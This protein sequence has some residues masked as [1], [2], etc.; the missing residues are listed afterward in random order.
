MI[1]YE[2]PGIKIIQG[3][4]LEMLKELPD[5]SI[6]TV[7]TSPPYWGLRDYQTVPQIWDG[8]KDCQHSW[9][10]Y[11][12]PAN[13]WGKPNANVPGIFK[14]P[15]SNKPVVK[16]Q[17]LHFCS[18]CGA[19]KGS[20]GLEPSPELFVKH[21]TDIFREIKRILKKEGTVWLNLG[22]SYVSGKSRYSSSPQ[23]IS[24]KDRGE[25]TEQNKP[26]LYYHPYLKDKDLCGIPWRVAFALQQPYKVPV[27]VK[28]ETDR[29][30]LAAMFDGE[31][32]IG[33]RR[34]SSYRKEVE[35]VYQDGFVAYTVVT[36]NDIELLEKC[37]AI[38]GKGKVA[39]KQ[40]ANTTDNRGIV[41]R[42]DSYGW[43]LDG[44]DAVD[45]VR[46]IYPYLIAKR[47]Q[48][49]LVYTL[50][51]IHKNKQRVDGKVPKD[52][53]DKK[54][55]LYETI[56]KCNQRESVNIPNWIEEPKQKIEDGWY[57]RQDIIWQ[58]PN[59]MP[60]S[61]TDRCT[62][63]HEYI[64]LLTKSPKYYFDNEAIKE[65]Q[66]A[67]SLVRAFATDHLDKRK[68]GGDE[69]YALSG[70]RQQEAHSKLRMVINSGE[71]P[72][73]NKRSVWTVTTKSFK[74]AHFATFNEEL[75]LPCVLAG[76]PKEGIILDPFCGSGTTGAVAKN[77]MR[78]FIGIELNA[79]Y[80]EI[81]KQRIKGI[82]RPML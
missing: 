4:C 32:C 66:A 61:V 49:C 60:E 7:I 43:R 33:I 82:T 36:N 72:M 69:P 10:G 78:N 17:T 73:R 52:V 14:D 56:K 70:K 75:I 19:W 50:D 59:P 76:C 77:N 21:L 29:A 28:K 12:R 34:F 18:K 26:D 11:T 16:A 80:C 9:D 48:A 55:F 39:L 46:A 20:L 45:V 79:E 8:D 57:L 68:M 22:D 41:S 31:G 35:Q 2:E 40:K 67:A 58:K 42:K 62:K 37:I 13:T 53:Q 38:T 24:G 74:G 54:V 64:F 25:P 65:P 3:D 71:T 63:S 15:E 6:D 47:K 44:N 51:I 1:Y 27:C 81:A 30:W 5:E 23:T